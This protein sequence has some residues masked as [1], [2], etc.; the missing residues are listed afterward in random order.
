MESYI[1]LNSSL[2]REEILSLNQLKEYLASQNVNYRFDL[3]NSEFLIRFLRSC[4]FN[5]KK[6]YIKLVNYFKFADEHDIENI[7]QV[8]F[9]NTDKLKL[10]FPHG[11]HKVTKE[12]LPIFLQSLG[13]LK[14]D[15]INRLLPEKKLNQYICLLL[16]RLR[17]VILPRTSQAL[18]KQIKQVFVLVDLKGLTTSLMSKK[19]FYFV[20]AQLSIC[21][22][23]YP[24]IFGQLY[25]VNTGFVF[26]A[27]WAAYKYFYDQSTRNRIRLLG[28]DYHSKLL[29]VINGLNLPKFLGGDCNCE[30]YGCIFSDAGPWNGKE[31]KRTNTISYLPYSNER[32]NMLE[33]LSL[34]TNK[35]MN[36]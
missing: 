27:V 36:K 11:F 21:E 29:E 23:Y 1:D 17:K 5:I 24:C 34:N 20:N 15:D 7:E 28:F 8:P 33:H 4:S 35:T 10:F 3:Y 19:V 31:I 12:G 9:P 32:E 16:E 2:T 6:T 26:R 25:F 30:P 18:E 22:N 14:I 13:D